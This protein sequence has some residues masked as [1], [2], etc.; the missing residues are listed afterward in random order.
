MTE[1][2]ATNHNLNK[3]DKVC[4]SGLWQPWYKRLFLFMFKEYLADLGILERFTTTMHTVTNVTRDS[5]DFKR[6]G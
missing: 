3:G 5:F 1:M 2:H 4:V 6:Q